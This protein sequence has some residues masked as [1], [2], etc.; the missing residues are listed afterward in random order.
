MMNQQ[1]I[2]GRL[3][4]LIPEHV[5]EMPD[6]LAYMAN[7]AAAV[8]ELADAVTAFDGAP[9]SAVRLARAAAAYCDTLGRIVEWAGALRV[10]AEEVKGATVQ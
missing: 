8:R 2:A 1:R 7:L 5:R 4:E 10:A 3:L 9:A 6:C